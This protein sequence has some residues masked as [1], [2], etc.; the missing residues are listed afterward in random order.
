MEGLVGRTAVVKDIAE[1]KRIVDKGTKDTKDTAD[2][3]I[4]AII[5]FRIKDATEDEDGAYTMLTI[6]MKIQCVNNLII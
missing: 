3:A 1:V 4:E 2:E 6:I 5:A